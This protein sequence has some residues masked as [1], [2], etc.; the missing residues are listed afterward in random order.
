[1]VQAGGSNRWRSR[2]IV[3]ALVRVVAFLVPVAAA[4]AA[5]LLVS[6]MV[7]ASAQHGLLWIVVVLAVPAGVATL[8]NR[9]ARRLLPLTALCK[10]SLVFPDHAPSRIAR[11]GIDVAQLRRV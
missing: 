9:A 2:P 3:G 11:P 8:T 1:M 5:S 7:P 4:V 10:L 6:G